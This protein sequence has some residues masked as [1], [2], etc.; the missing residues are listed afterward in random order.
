MYDVLDIEVGAGQGK[1]KKIKVKNDLG[2][3]SWYEVNKFVLFA[4][5]SAHLKGN[6]AAGIGQ[7]AARS[8]TPDGKQIYMGIDVAG[9]ADMTVCGKSLEM[10]DIEKGYTARA[11]LKIGEA[12]AAGIEAGIAFTMVNRKGR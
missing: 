3:E 8:A 2:Y 6:A 9:G 12:V 1:I 11:A 10:T 7:S 4:E 5:A